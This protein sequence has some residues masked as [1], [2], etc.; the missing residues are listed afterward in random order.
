MTI[1]KWS[2]IWALT[3]DV[4]TQFSSGDKQ[5]IRFHIFSWKTSKCWK[6]T[7]WLSFIHSN[8]KNFCLIITADSLFLLTV[9]ISEYNR[10]CFQSYKQKCSWHW[11]FF[12]QIL[13]MFLDLTST[14]KESEWRRVYFFL[15]FCEFVQ[16]CIALNFSIIFH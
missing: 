2:C 10:K 9:K 7:N 11:R 4:N 14:R 1:L 6:K 16:L 8:K 13:I 5:N 3:H 15:T 12:G